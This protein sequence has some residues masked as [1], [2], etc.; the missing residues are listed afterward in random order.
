MGK[1]IHLVRRCRY[2][3]VA[4]A[5]AIL[6]TGLGLALYLGAGRDD[7]FIT[8]WAGEMLAKGA[9]FVNYNM[10]RVE[11]SSSLLH[12]LIVMVLAWLAP[13]YLYTLNKLA[14]LLA[15]CAVFALIYRHRQTLLPL[16]EGR[17]PALLIVLAVLAVLPSFVYWSL[18]GLETPF[19]TLLLLLLTIYYLRFWER[20]SLGNEAALILF[21]ALFLLVRPETFYII[22][23][24]M[25]F[26]GFFTWC[27]G[28]R[29][30]LL[31][32]LV[33]PALLF[34]VLGMIRWHA[35]G[36]FFPNPVSAKTGDL[37]RSVV[38]G[39]NYL[40]EFYRSSYFLL[41]LGAVNLALVPYFGLL[42]LRAV[43]NRDLLKSRAEGKMI[44]VL[45]LGITVHLVV[46]LAGGD[47]ME[48]YRFM[49]PVTPLVVILPALFSMKLYLRAE[50]WL[51]GRLRP[52][53]MVYLHTFLV[54]I[55]L[56]TVGGLNLVQ[57]SLVTS[58]QGPLELHIEYMPLAYG[59][60][61]LFSKDLGLDERIKRLNTAYARDRSI[62]FDFLDG[63]FVDLHRQSG[64]L[65][66]ATPQMGLFPY[67]LKKK[68]P[69]FDLYFVDTYGLCDPRA[70]RLDMPGG[71]CG[72]SLGRQ[73]TK[74]FADEAG[75]LSEYVRSMRP[76][77]IYMLY[78]KDEEVAELAGRG[79]RAALRMPGA[80][81]LF[82]PRV[83]Y[84]ARAPDE[85]EPRSSR[86]GR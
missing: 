49:H 10:E 80:N 81:I 27:R 21:Q 67:Y 68:Y 60:G 54:V 66:I 50:A 75:P 4:T 47:W 70:A 31:R 83:E 34:L 6:F 61:D 36:T 56:A 64:K 39:L 57:G 41:V 7:T 13:G 74:I 86:F 62:L 72:I 3:L 45:G 25:V 38:Q 53:G 48:F 82:N 30:S 23:F 24:T 51:K 8:L 22:P 52:S 44:F 26:V 40:G 17:F 28:W 32:M 63:P 15:G 84:E 85:Q 19:V 73:M 46:I 20:P 69:D 55:G 5:A 1:A 16:R 79:F 11:I 42:V 77:M 2:G 65:V 29:T 59:P 71:S 9:G 35:F 76:N 43:K 14:G 18:G 58:R 78:M 33:L 37:S 12:T